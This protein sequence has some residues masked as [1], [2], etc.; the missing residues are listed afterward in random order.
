MKI[1]KILGSL[2][3]FSAVISILF[4][5]LLNENGFCYWAELNAEVRTLQKH[6]KKL[7]IKKIELEDYKN[8]LEN[9]IFYTEKIAREKY[10]MAQE[11]DYI[12]LEVENKNV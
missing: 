11:S 6:L 4:I 1:K 8:N 7:Q 9:N 12:F 5:I 2:I 3:L 10:Q